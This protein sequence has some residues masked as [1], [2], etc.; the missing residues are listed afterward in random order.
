MALVWRDKNH[1][2]T[3]IY[4]DLDNFKHVNDTFGH[5][6]G[7]KVLEKLGEIIRNTIRASDMGFRIG[8]DEFAIIL[9]K[10]SQENG[11]KVA[12]RSKPNFGSLEFIFNEKT[13]FSVGLSIGVSEYKDGILLKISSAIPITN[14]TKPNTEGKTRSLFREAPSR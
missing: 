2:F 8:G 5:Y 12:K 11:K 7:D 14:S 1:T 6:S 3:L 13:V 10:S 4:I 9:K